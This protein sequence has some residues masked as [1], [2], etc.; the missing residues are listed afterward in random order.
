MRFLFQADRR[1][2]QLLSRR[3]RKLKMPESLPVHFRSGPDPEIDLG[4]FRENLPGKSLRLFTEHCILL[5]L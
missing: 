4:I 5:D 3:V 1:A 2:G